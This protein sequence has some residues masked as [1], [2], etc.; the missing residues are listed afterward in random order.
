MKILIVDDELDILEFLSYALRKEGFTVMTAN[1]GN[2][3]L[4]LAKKHKPNLIILDVMMPEK[5]GFE[6]CK[7]IREIKELDNSI[8]TFLSARSEDYSESAG[9]TAGADDYIFKPI[10]PKL[11]ISR[12]N[13]LLKSKIKQDV[14]N[15]G[16][17]YLD[18]V[19]KKLLYN[20]KNIILRNDEFNLLHLLMSIPGKIFS[21]EDII[22]KLWRE[23]PRDSKFINM[24]IKRIKEKLK[25]KHIKTIKRIGYKFDL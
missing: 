8:V 1:N 12:V 14:I 3:G 21:D 9:Y 5:D 11:L 24:N 13:F 18:L 7:E 16:D 22:Y 25:N 17:I 15:I 23:E 6:V 19:H 2:E 4:I 10:N 20:G